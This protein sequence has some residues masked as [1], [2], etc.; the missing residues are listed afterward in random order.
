MYFHGDLSS[1]QTSVARDQAAGS[2]AVIGVVVVVTIDNSGS[3]LL[4][5]LK[6]SFSNKHL[7]SAQELIVQTAAFLY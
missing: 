1:E 3:R 7:L 6:V 2:E 5:V 4:N